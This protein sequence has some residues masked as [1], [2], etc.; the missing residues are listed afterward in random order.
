MKIPPVEQRNF[1]GRTLQLLRGAQPT[2]TAA[3]DYDAVTW[4]HSQGSCGRNLVQQ[5][6]ISLTMI[7]SRRIEPLKVEARKYF[8]QGG[9]EFNGFNFYG[10]VDRVGKLGCTAFGGALWR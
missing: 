8:A 9:A 3:E 2:K 10:P 1:H 7:F 5:S 6:I 4:C